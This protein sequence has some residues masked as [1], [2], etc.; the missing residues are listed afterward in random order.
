LSA[1]LHRSFASLSVPNY[2]RYFIGQL[3]SLSGNWM[4]TVA[5][6]WLILSL[7]GSGVAVG[8]TA[9]LQFLPMLLFGVWGGLLADRL[10]KRRLLIATQALMALPALALWSV[11]VSGEV[12][13]TL[14]YLLVFARG[15]VNAVDN[16]TRQS[17]VMEMVGPDRLV[18]AVGLNSLLIHSARIAGPA[19][20]G[21]LIA[22]VGVAPCFL[23]NALSFG[24][25]IVALR[26]MDRTELQPTPPAPRRRGALR[27]TLRY[28]AATPALAVPLAMMAL[29]GTL[30]FNFQVILPLLA[31]FTFDGGATAYSVLAVAMAAGAVIGSL[32]TGARGRVDMRLLVAAALGFGAVALV[33]AAA[34]TLALEALVLIPLGAVSVTF[35]AGVNSTLQLEVA[36]EAR[37]QVMALYSMVFLG[38]TPIGGPIAGW[39]SEAA[40]PR[41]ALLMTAAAALTAGAAAHVY[42]GRRRRR[43]RVPGRAAIAAE[44]RG[45]DQLDGLQRGAGLDV[46]ADAVALLDRGDSVLAPAPGERDADRVA[47]AHDGHL[48]PDPRQPR[49]DQREGADRPQPH[50][51]DPARALGG[52]AGRRACARQRPGHR[53]ARARGA[54]EDGAP[55]GGDR[56][57][58]GRHDQRGVV[59]VL[60]GADHRDGSQGGGDPGGEEHGHPEQVAEEHR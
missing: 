52:E 50:E 27:A 55:D 7:T 59:G 19:G 3:V 48:R 46:E 2:R 43:G 8:L 47:G 31:R 25:M 39:L 22:T 6:V 41:A 29:V 10:P 44:P 45:A 4:Q 21:V 58:R 16:P 15:A 53:L 56:P 54:A 20:A 32:V 26:S 24:A 57:P 35:A 38:S 9:A 13:P 12:T 5:E 36:P 30:G 40:G 60:V 1:A 42:L 23:I 14:V 28:V 49:R 37:G 17:F 33:A 34:P 51:R 18:N 11:T